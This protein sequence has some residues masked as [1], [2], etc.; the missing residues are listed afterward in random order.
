MLLRLLG[1]PLRAAYLASVFVFLWCVAQ[2]FHADSGFSSLISIGDML[3]DSKVT[4]LRQV[5]H[6]VYESSPGYDGAYYVQ[7]ALYPTL[8]NPELKKAI[9]NL[10]YR[11]RRILFSWTAWALG[12]GQ[13]AWIVQAHALLNVLCWLVLGWALLRWFP[14]TSWENFLRWAAVMFS[15]GLCMSARHS[16]VDGPSLLLVALALRWLEDGRRGAGAATLAL[17]G[18]G[19][20][21]SLLATAGL[22]F[23][24]R[25]PR[26]WGRTALTIALIAL[27]LAAWMLFIK[28]KFGPADDPGLG[29]FTLP[30]AGYVE[31]WR[32]AWRATSGPTAS[33]LR[34]ATF[35]VVVALGVQWLFFALRWRP[36]ERW[37]RVGA[38]FALMMGFLSTP[39]WEG[40]PGAATRVLLPMT[41]AF[42]ILVPRGRRWFAVLIAGNLTVAA[43][44]F[45]FSPPHEF[46]VLRG[47]RALRAA[48]RVV[49]VSGGWYGP[50][51]HLEQHWR[52]SSGRAELRVTNSSGRPLQMIVR[53]QAS[54]ADGLRALRVLLSDR[55]LWGDTVGQ[56]FT[57]IRFGVAL[58]PG[59]SVFLFTTDKPPQKID[60]DPRDL[61]FQ[62]ANLDI[63][64]QPAGGSR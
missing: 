52:W 43:S 44:V 45:E 19:K 35:A 40:F 1:K 4:A 61:A 26:T 39:V 14:A 31:K 38:A 53:A 36:Q 30:F 20:E 9:D 62:V 27:P 42:N 32:D 16:L 54:S 5:P 21:T 47:D 23:D 33:E 7:L 51:R 11:A 34:W 24:W 29:N 3:G 12:L 25:A 18:L 60:H 2:F 49:P 22:D 13:P 56:G 46:Y 17:A 10:P 63:V 55:L 64:L 58:P 6:Y 50:E 8:D 15:H 37:W 28:W 59:E 41:L 57:E 48:V